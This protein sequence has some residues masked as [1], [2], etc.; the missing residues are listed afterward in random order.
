MISLDR[1]PSEL[2]AVY[3][4]IDDRDVETDTSIQEPNQPG[5]ARQTWT[6]IFT[7]SQRL[8][9]GPDFME[10]FMFCIGWV[11]EKHLNQL[12]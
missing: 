12:T 8:W 1:L 6:W 5:S 7:L 10:E 11:M 2:L 9:P 4:D 3:Q